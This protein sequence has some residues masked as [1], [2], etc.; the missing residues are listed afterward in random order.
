MR[1]RFP[2]Q[3]G[4]EQKSERRLVEIRKMVHECRGT[5][6]GDQRQR[7]IAFSF[8]PE[9]PLFRKTWRDRARRIC[10]PI[11]SR[12]CGNMLGFVKVCLVRYQIDLVESAYILGVRLVPLAA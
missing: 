10:R 1:N 2:V 12:L 4:T 9:E 6:A 8:W 3:S 11:G 7:G 5:E